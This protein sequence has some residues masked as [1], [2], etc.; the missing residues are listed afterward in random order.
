MDS[1]AGA[2]LLHVGTYYKLFNKEDR[3]LE[4]SRDPRVS[5]VAANKSRIKQLGS[6]RLRVQVGEFERVCKFYVVPNY[7]RPIFGLPDLT[8]MQL[9]RFSMPIV[10]QWTEGETSIDE[11]SGPVP[12]SSG[13]TKDEVLEGFKEVFTGLGRL[14]VE[15]VKIHL[16]KDAKPVRRPCRRV[17]I[18]IRGKFKDELDSLCKEKVLTKLD[19]NEVTEWLNSFV[20]VGQ[21]G[22]LIKGLFGSKWVKPIYY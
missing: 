8:R 5:L 10:S 22:H 1:G 21:R 20:N 16:T 18:A 6:V 13:L 12:I 7:V 14:K 17:P 15:P 3:D 19:K 9:V 2:N 4:A 11:A